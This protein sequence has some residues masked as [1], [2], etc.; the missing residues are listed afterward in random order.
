LYLPG[1]QAAE[2]ALAK[3]GPGDVLVFDDFAAEYRDIW[4]EIGEK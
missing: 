3:I 1:A 2:G 4:Q